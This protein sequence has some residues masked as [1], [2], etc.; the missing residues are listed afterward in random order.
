MS[1]YFLEICIYRRVNPFQP[2]GNFCSNSVGSSRTHL[3]II[4]THARLEWVRLLFGP[5]PVLTHV[6][7]MIKLLW[8]T[9]YEARQWRNELSCAQLSGGEKDLEQWDGVPRSPRPLRS[10]ELMLKFLAV[11]PLP[12]FLRVRHEICKATSH[13]VHQHL[14]SVTINT[15]TAADAV[16]AAD[17]V[18]YL[19]CIIS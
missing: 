5:V 7:R 12:P 1:P 18:G 9:K 19:H 2:V 6:I 16:E 10:C 17:V 11:E 4:H 15:D 8:R 14:G 3:C 13:S